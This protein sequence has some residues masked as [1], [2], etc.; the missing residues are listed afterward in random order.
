M[1]ALRD[2]WTNIVPALPNANGL[3]SDGAGGPAVPDVFAEAAVSADA[4]GGI[5]APT[6]TAADPSPQ[7]ASPT[8]KPR[9]RPQRPVG[10]L[11]EMAKWVWKA[12]QAWKSLS[13][14]EQSLL[15][16]HMAS[17]YGKDFT[18]Q[19]LEFTKS[20]G[21]TDSRSFGG[22]FPELTA[23]WFK[24]HGYVLL[25]QDPLRQ[26][27][28]HPSGFVMDG[29]FGAVGATRAGAIADQK[30]FDDALAKLR[31]AVEAIGQ[32]E[33]KLHY[34]QKYWDEQ[35]AGPTDP[36]RPQEYEEYVK[37]LESMKS[38][39]EAKQQEAQDIR[40]QLAPKGIDVSPLDPLV[41]ELTRM[42]QWASTQL[43]EDNLDPYKP[44]DPSDVQDPPAPVDPPS[45]FGGGTVP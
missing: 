24:K 10:E 8:A 20:G 25:Q 28:V 13:L 26:W 39:A 32:V 23:D 41:G 35:S 36:A 34:R 17:L 9:P 29:P 4:S 37:L 6:A 40:K 42:A 7:P 43:E 2:F 5:P 16:A 14:V 30:A 21:R 44:R 15:T 3:K 1:S 18:E 38:Q 45:D 33:G 12:H 19:F 22:P 11:Q 27:W 31:A